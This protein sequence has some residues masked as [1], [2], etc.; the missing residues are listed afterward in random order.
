[1]KHIVV[2][3]SD[4][5]GNEAQYQ[6]LVDYALQVSAD[7]VIVGGDIAPK[8]LPENEFIPVQRAFFQERLPTLFSPIKNSSTKVYLMMGNDD[9]AANYDVFEEGEE[10]GLYKII[11]GKRL[12]LTD[13][14]DIVGYSC[15]PIT[16][17][18]IKDWEKFDLSD[19]PPHLAR[20]YEDRKR[21]NYNLDAHKSSVEGWIPFRFTPEMEKRDSI[22]NDLST[23]LFQ[24]DPH[25]TVYVMHAPPNNTNLDIILTGN[26]VGSFAERLFIE[27]RQPFLTLH[28]HIHET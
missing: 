14:F 2:Y 16:P 23:K 24:E 13:D 1:M 4:I 19:V 5:H 12:K 26:H 27:Q 22:Q 7:S 15:V 28:G 8:G 20:D 17:F 21:K 11:H 18:G 3:T 10:D 25:K 6:K 9:C